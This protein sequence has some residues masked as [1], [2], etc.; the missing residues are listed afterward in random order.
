HAGIGFSGPAAAAALAPVRDRRYTRLI[1]LAPAHPV[2]DRGA[3]LPLAR[4]FR[5][6]LGDVPVDLA[7]VEFLSHSPL[8]VREDA[9]FLE[10]HS[11]DAVLPFVQR[12]LGAVPMVPILVGSTDVEG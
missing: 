4:A 8:F 5:T 12:A 10:E 9:P 1:I 3:V 7:A 6:P 11:V 2:L